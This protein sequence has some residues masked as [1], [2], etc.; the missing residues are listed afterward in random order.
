MCGVRK[1]VEQFYKYSGGRAEEIWMM[2]N[3]QMWAEHWYWG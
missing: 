2:S 1:M 3:F